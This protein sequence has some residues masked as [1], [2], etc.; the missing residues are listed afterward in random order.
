MI[1]AEI[2][3][4]RT[5]TGTWIAVGIGAVGLLLTQVLAVTLIPALAAGAIE[6]ADVGA[7]LGGIDPGSLAFQAASLNP[8]G[9]AIG[10]TG[11][12][13]IASIVVM[14]LG[15]LVATTD[16]RFGGLVTT[17]LAQPRR[18][19]I[20]GGKIGSTALA[21]AALAVLFVVICLGTLLITTTLSPTIEFVV[22]VAQVLGIVARSVAVIVLLALLGLAIGVLVRSQL[23]GVL[24]VIALLILEPIVQS[25]V[26]LVTGGVPF[27]AQLLPLSLGQAAIADG[28]SGALPAVIALP[29]LCAIVLI[30]TAAAG[31]V[32]RRRD[33]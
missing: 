10:S 19:R 26:Q 33:L 12:I 31:A 13:G 24:V 14:V 7:E 16:Y 11:S 5:V 25:I 1:R 22:P 29:A 23:A 9:S 6:G 8:L 4:L 21:S 20:L 28:S 18:L 32:L 3:K 27:W 17:A 30:V 2:L 15:L